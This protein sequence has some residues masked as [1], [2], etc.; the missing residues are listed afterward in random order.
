MFK[1]RF[2]Q[3]VIL[4]NLI[5]TFAKLFFFLMLIC[6]CI[7]TYHLMT[8]GF[9][10]DKIRSNFTNSIFETNDNIN[11]N[12]V[13]NQKYSYLSKGCQTYVFESEDKKYIIKFIRYHRYQTPLWLN[14]CNFL[15]KYRN[16]R[17]FYKEKLLL[18]SLKSY[19]IAVNFLKDETATL[20]VHLNKTRNFDRRLRILDSL[21]REYLID[22]NE[23]GFVVQKKVKSFEDVLN[24]YKNNERELKKLVYSFLNTTRYIYQKGFINDDYNCIKNSGVIDNKVI[25]LDV[26]SFLLKDNLDTKKVFEKEFFR[27]VRYF[28]KWADKNAPFLIAYIDDEINKMALDL[29]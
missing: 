25:H 13:F 15:K 17:L 6:A 3:A 27:Y 5:K 28:K 8:K 16:I 24:K 7:K 14:V 26:G 19:Q 22:L 12:D 29:K 21:K 10:A 20:Y 9:R 11:D 18:N 1:N 2:I 23:A 4:M